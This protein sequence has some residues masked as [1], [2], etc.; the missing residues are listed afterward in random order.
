ML[1]I[2]S[3]RL[4][5]LEMDLLR[6]V[7]QMPNFNTFPDKIKALVFEAY[8]F[9]AQW[10]SSVGMRKQEDAFYNAAL[11]LAH[12]QMTLLDGLL[13]HV[14]TTTQR[15]GPRLNDK[16][17]THRD[18]QAKWAMAIGDLEF[19]SYFLGDARSV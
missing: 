3:D 17:K 16:L 4:A 7:I 9:Q 12:M 1:H 6:Y 10:L 19:N 13:A 14:Q 11:L 5:V 18:R 2:V 8:H 15:D